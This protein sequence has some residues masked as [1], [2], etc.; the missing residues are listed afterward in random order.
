MDM[1][2]NPYEVGLGWQVDS[3]KEDFVGKAALA[4]IK[5][6]GVTHKLAGITF[7]GEPVTWYPADFYHVKSNNDELVGH[8]TSAWYSPT[9]QMNVGFAFLPVAFTKLGTQLSVSL[10]NLYN[11][12]GALVGAEVVKTPFK[13]SEAE[14]MGT[15]LRETGSK[16]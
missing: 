4:K 8:V 9:L 13:I 3:T 5:A 10:P 16:L 15:G 14:E 2:T 7:G 12:T 6:E 11:P 1:E